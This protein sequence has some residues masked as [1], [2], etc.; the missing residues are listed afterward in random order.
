TIPAGRTL[1]VSDNVELRVRGVLQIDGTLRGIP[2]NNA[3][4]FLG[5]VYG[6]PGFADSQN[7][8]QQSQAKGKVVRGRNA[9]MPALNIVNAGGDLQG[10]P[11]DLRGSGGADGGRSFYW[12]RAQSATIAAGS[13]GI[14]GSG[15]AGLAVIARGIAFGV[16]GT[17][18][19]T[20]GHG[21]PGSGFGPRP[22]PGG[23]GGGGAPGGVVLLVDGTGNP[24]PVLTNNKLI[25]CYGHSP[26]TPGSAGLGDRCLG[27]SAAR[28]LFVPKSRTP[29]DDYEDPALD[30]GVQ[31]AMD[32]AAAAQADATA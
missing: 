2:G 1:N 16:S 12:N 10:I 28:L 20:G 7:P 6:G 24:M 17:L 3:A 9:V 31:Q 4:G 11:D 32:A 27:T 29:Y 13:G 14:G 15:G 30:P 8:Y 26:D 21:G 22:I 18:Q 5:S 25:A 19:T 23:S